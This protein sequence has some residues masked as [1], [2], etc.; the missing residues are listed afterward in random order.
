MS[1]G[2]LRAGGWGLVLAL[3]SD[4]ETVIT[5]ELDLDNQAAIRRRLPSLANRR[6]QA[7]RRS[8]GARA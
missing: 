7:Y 3:A 6:P 1:L 2:R 4:E 5:A 8:A